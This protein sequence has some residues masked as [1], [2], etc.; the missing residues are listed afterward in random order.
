MSGS[1]HGSRGLAAGSFA[2]GKHPC[3]R[4]G[5][6]WLMVAGFVGTTA[7]IA[8]PCVRRAGA[9]HPVQAA[10]VCCLQPRGHPGPSW[11]SS[12]LRRCPVAGQAVQR[13]DPR[14]WPM[15]TGPGDV[16]GRSSGG[17]AS[18]PQGAV[19]TAR[20]GWRG[21]GA[22]GAGGV[23]GACRGLLVGAAVVGSLAGVAVAGGVV[24][25]GMLLAGVVVG[26]LVGAAA[27]E[28]AAVVV[29]WSAPGV[30]ALVVGCA[31][32]A[33]SAAM[34]AGAPSR[35]A[36]RPPRRR[37]ADATAGS[38]SWDRVLESSG[39]QHLIGPNH[40]EHAPNAPSAHTP[41]LKRQ[42]LASVAILHPPIRRF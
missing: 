36:R 27:V 15:G 34:A 33:W 39:K 12:S 37:T 32:P 2:S 30:P 14:L 22:G 20:S 31:A 1:S 17:R 40:P 35:A 29:G 8:G 13:Y 28:G 3:R 16:D 11:R 7:M 38:C 25:A 23:R 9:V 26:A 19:I 42:P 10:A 5:A 4:L 41:A 6:R 18:C 21:S 24:V